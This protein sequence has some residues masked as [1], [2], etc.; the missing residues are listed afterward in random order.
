MDTVTRK[1]SSVIKRAKAWNQAN[2]I[3][4]LN[5]IIIGW[6][7]YHRSVVS[8]EVFRNLDPLHLLLLQQTPSSPHLT[9]LYKNYT[10]QASCFLFV[11]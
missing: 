9:P 11:P 4:A 10:Y 2:L 8:A 7:N 5:P 6:S 1:V 3:D